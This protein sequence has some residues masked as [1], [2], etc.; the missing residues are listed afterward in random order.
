MAS[1]LPFMENLALKR[2]SC[3]DKKF[4]D[5]HDEQSRACWCVY[6][7]VL[8]ARA[9]HGHAAE[10]DSRLSRRQC[11]HLDE[12]SDDHRGSRSS[13]G[14]LGGGASADLQNEG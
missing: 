4:I 13:D 12:C 2:V 14:G 10:F 1:R 3:R 8:Q 5:C 7:S 9:H 6:M 11:L